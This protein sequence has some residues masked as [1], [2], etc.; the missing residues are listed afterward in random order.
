L[1]N[2]NFTSIEL[3]F[4]FQ[5][6]SSVKNIPSGWD[7]LA[8]KLFLS[9]DYLEV[10]TMSAQKNIQCHFIGLF[11][12]DELVGIAVSQYIN[13]REVNSFGE[14]DHC[15]KLSFEILSLKTSAQMSLFRQ[16]YAKWTKRML[17]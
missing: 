6:Y 3:P 9:R 1:T 2:T 16:Q 13:L 7:S 17:F 11:L 14:R 15:V 8:K 5:I 10:L 12:N 4:S